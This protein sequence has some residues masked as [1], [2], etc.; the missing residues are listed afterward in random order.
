[1]E[2]VGQ[3]LTLEGKDTQG[4]TVKT[5]AF[6]AK[7]CSFHY[8]ATSYPTCLQDLSLLKDMLAKYGPENVAIVGY[9]CGHGAGDPRRL[10]QE[11]S[12]RWPQLYDAGGLDSPLV[13]SL[14]DP[15]SAHD[16][17]RRQGGQSRQSQSVGG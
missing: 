16:A 14:G 8:W 12:I 13:N 4:N 2:S 17:A 11:N 10:P 6:R 15:H 5:I 3:P 7:S 9:Q 1:M